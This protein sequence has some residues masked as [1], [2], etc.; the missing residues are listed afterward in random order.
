MCT[1]GRGGMITLRSVSP[2]SY[3]LVAGEYPFP[4]TVFS[5]HIPVTNLF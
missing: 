5:F 4:V 3:L 1:N 2:G